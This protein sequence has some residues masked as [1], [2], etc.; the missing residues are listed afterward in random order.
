MG[1]TSGHQY[2][3]DV[4]QLRLELYRYGVPTWECKQLSVSR[5][6]EFCGE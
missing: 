3:M 2:N 1:G 5:E 6:S 4:W